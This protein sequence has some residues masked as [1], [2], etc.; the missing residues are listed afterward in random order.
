MSSAQRYLDVGVDNDLYFGLDRYYSSGIFIS[1]GQQK[2]NYKQNEDYPKKY[3]HWTLGQEIYTPK[4]RYTKDVYLLDY[5]YGGW[6][7]LER[8]YEK[9]KTA[10]SAWGASLK[11]GMT[12]KASLA[13]Y[14]QN[15]YH[16][17]LKKDN[18]SWS[19][20]SSQ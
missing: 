10:F 17:Y 18:L 9:Y 1:V 3:T 12:G 6:L 16:D 20:F 14:F 13:P 4:N 7:F 11:L 2:H 15:L 8:C 19:L 5:P